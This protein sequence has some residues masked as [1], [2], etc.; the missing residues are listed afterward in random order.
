MKKTNYFKLLALAI[1]CCLSTSLSAQVNADSLRFRTVFDSL[2]TVGGGIINLTSNVPVR[3]IKNQTYVLESDATDPIQIN[4]NQFEIISIGTNVTADSTILQIGN[5]VSIL[6]TSTVLGNLSR[7]IL[8]IN[9]GLIQSTTSTSGT[10]A[11]LANA[12]WIYI[13]GGTINLVATG[14]VNAYAL[15]VLNNFSL[16]LRGGT[17]SATGD[18]TRAVSLTDGVTPNTVKPFSGATIT[19]NGNGAY[20]IQCLGGNTL[21]IGDNTTV[22][23]TSSL[24]TDAALVVAGSASS[25]ILI[26]STANNVTITSSIP[27]K[28]DAPTSAVLDLRGTINITASPVT[29]STL[30]YPANNVTL[31][32]S[33]SNAS[34]ALAGIYFSY[35]GNPTIVNPNIANGNSVPASTAATTIK[36]SIGKNGIIDANVFTFN[37]TVNNLPANAVQPIYS[38]AA[39]KAAYVASQT[40]TVDTTRLKLMA[41]VTDS[42]TAYSITPDATHPMTID[43]NGFQIN[44][45]YGAASTFTITIGGNLIIRNYLVPT[46]GMFRIYGATTTNFTGGSYI[47][48]ASKPIIDIETGSSISD[49]GTQINLSNASFIANGNSSASSI[50]KTVTSNG[51]LFSATNCTF[52]LNAKAVAF[53]FNGTK[54]I[55]IKNCT[56]NILGSDATSQ[57][58]FQ[59]PTSTATGYFSN[60]SIDGLALSMNAGNVFNWGTVA[61]VKSPINTIIKDLTLTGSATI[62][63]PSGT[64]TPTC[65]FYDFRAFTPTVDVAPGNY[66]STQTVTPSLTAVTGISSVDAGVATF[67]Y[68]LDGTD[69]ILTSSTTTPVSI[70]ATSTLKMAA[71]SADGLFLGKI[72]SFPYT[73]TTTEVAGLQDNSSISV[74]PTVVENTVT[75]N[76]M[77]K[78]ILVMDLAGKLVL[79][80]SNATHFDMSSIKAGVY[81]VKIQATNNSVR[82]IKVV[83]L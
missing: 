27:Y 50:I 73:F 72:Y 53:N 83:K 63:K 8:R 43:E 40:S 7:G 6:G 17:I 36:A 60:L 44:I 37:Y 78:Q 15:T 45:G 58:F 81:L 3:L 65:K 26:P 56:L 82:T 39:L 74:Y 2:K 31:T 5:N 16:V 75:V 38:F 41:T 32:A 49:T 48:N 69:P 76:K 13:S 34:I 24:G 68:T 11:V 54:N 25:Y 12:G 67:V 1:I 22:T 55:N 80:K 59:G 61:T 23:T 77:A 33:G 21:T 52:T 42:I 70:S 46:N 30:T 51:Y 79:E 14:V 35:S 9:G 66:T 18:N 20:G 28:L 71:K 10:S 4:A 29:G 62:A 47:L 19:A 64:Y 57:G